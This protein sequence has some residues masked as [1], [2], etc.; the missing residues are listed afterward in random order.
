MLG[1]FAALQQ[2][3]AGA[4]VK[5]ALIDDPGEGLDVRT[6]QVFLQG[7]GFM[8]GRGLGQGDEQ[9][10][11]KAGSRRRSRSFSTSSGC[12]LRA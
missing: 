8:H 3:I 12:V 5:Q 7:G 6:T 10:V 1:G 2:G 9:D 4:A 11:V